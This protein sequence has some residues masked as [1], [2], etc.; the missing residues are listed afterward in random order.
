MTAVG[1]SLYPRI[2]GLS[3]EDN[4]IVASLIWGLTPGEA[5]GLLGLDQEAEELTLKRLTERFGAPS[6][7]ALPDA[8]TALIDGSNPPA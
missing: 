3:S 7:D 2:A 4:A 8:I 1:S 6:A 5:T